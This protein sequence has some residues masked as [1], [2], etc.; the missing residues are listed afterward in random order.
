MTLNEEDRKKLR[1]VFID[2]NTQSKIEDIKDLTIGDLEIRFGVINNLVEHY[3][4]YV[5]Y[6]NKD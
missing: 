3:I 6:S 4:H 1:A 2:I 5:L